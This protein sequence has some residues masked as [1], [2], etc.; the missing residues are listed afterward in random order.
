ML[1]RVKDTP[2]GFQRE[3][4]DASTVSR[5]WI[6]IA[7]ASVRYALSGV[8]GIPRAKGAA[9]RADGLVIEGRG[10]MQLKTS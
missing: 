7:W 9:A 4:E 3:T 5:A 1:E 6:A 2:T 8:R 10:P